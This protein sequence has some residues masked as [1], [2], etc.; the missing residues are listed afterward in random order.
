[1]D[2]ERK[3]VRKKTREFA[4]VSSSYP[5]QTF[6]QSHVMVP[7]SGQRFDETEDP[8][9]PAEEKNSESRQPH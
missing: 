5:I 8:C 2:I 3:E 1:M 6:I 7:E 9:V 4:D